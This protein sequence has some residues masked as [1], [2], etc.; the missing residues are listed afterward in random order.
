LAFIPLYL[1]SAQKGK[2]KSEGVSLLFPVATMKYPLTL[3]SPIGDCVVIP[4]EGRYKRNRQPS[5]SALGC[6]HLASWIII[7]LANAILTRAYSSV[8]DRQKVSA[9]KLRRLIA[10]SV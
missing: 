10:Y 8:A 6:G 9:L 7:L 4:M 2:V 5:S 3:S 1:K